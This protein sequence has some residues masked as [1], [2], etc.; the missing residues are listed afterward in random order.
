LESELKKLKV[1]LQVSVAQHVF[2]FA[3]GAAAK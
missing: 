1:D 3:F 2:P